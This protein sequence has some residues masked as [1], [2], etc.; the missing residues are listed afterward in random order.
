M[1][2]AE[3]WSMYL[4]IHRLKELGLNV[5]QIAR[6]LGI[7]RNTVYKYERLEPDEL[8]KAIKELKTRQKKLDC[9]G[10]EILSWLKE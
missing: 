6:H 7:S 5:S 4:E 9:V 10:G 1:K 3:R 8:E 2:I